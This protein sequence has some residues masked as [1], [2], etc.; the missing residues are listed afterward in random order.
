MKRLSTLMAILML[1]LLAM[2]NSILTLDLENSERRLFELELTSSSLTIQLEG[3]T[4]DET[5]GVVIGNRQG[6]TC[7]NLV[8]LHHDQT[9]IASTANMGGFEAKTTEVTLYLNLLHRMLH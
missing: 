8:T 3:L 1:P 2:A 6:A 9:L 5:Y 7:T 4:L